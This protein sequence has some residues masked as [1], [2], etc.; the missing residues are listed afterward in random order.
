[1]IYDLARFF[2]PVLLFS[3]GEPLLRKDL[4]ELN[5]L[6]KKIGLRT[7]LSTNGTLL[8]DE[9]ARRIKDSGFD[10]VGVS[11]DGIGVNNDRFRGKNGAYASSL[12]GIRN[13]IKYGVKTG[14]RYTITRHNYL[15]L[16]AVFKLA[17]VEGIRR[18]CFY[19][20]VYAGRG[21]QMHKDDLTHQKMRQ[22]LDLICEWVESLKYRGINKEVLTV[23]NHA[24]G[25]YIYLRLK[26]ENP[27][28]A[29]EA[30]KL[31]KING[32]NN[33]GIGIACVDNLGFVHPDQFWQSYSFGNVRKRPFSEIWQDS[34]QPLMRRLKERKSYLKG[35]CARC[36]F[37][38]ICNGNFRARAEAVYKDIWQEDPACYLSAE[39]IYGTK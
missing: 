31:L 27:Q 29:Q 33:S 13:L 25:V 19:H 12:S 16:P 5:V 23:D 18:V 24:D 30:L 34:R 15:D 4:F 37:L 6:A 8:T 36:L 3:G 14:L 28:R 11:L 21:S 10:Y 26:K 9:V 17:E 2:V 39:E 1:M 35:R 20:L 32:G 38:D 22:C 7:V